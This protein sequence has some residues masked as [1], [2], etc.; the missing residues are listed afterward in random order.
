MTLKSLEVPFEGASTYSEDYKL[1]VFRFWYNNSKR[2]G[3]W[4][5]KNIPLQVD[6]VTGKQITENVIDSWIKNDFQEYAL[7]LD[8]EVSKQLDAKIVQERVEMLSKHTVIALEL[9]KMGLE[10]LQEDAVLD[11]RVALQ[12]L[13][14]GI[15]IERE[16]RGIPLEELLKFKDKTDKELINTLR[17]ILTEDSELL[18]IEPNEPNTDKT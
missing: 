6:H 18:A 16:S 5:A 11:S 9:Q 14:K 1:Y 12:M 10:Y 15:E 3:L 2:G 17:S 7:S 8:V 4:V 13:V